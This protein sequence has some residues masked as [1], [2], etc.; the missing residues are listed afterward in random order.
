MG[1]PVR[2]P[3]SKIATPD[4]PAGFAARHHLLEQLDRATAEQLLVVIAP[5]GYGKTVLL[6]DW[7]RQPGGPPTAWITVDAGD[8]AP[9]LWS[10]LLAALRAIPNLPAD[11]PLHDVGRGG[12]RAVDVVD[13]LAAA[14]DATRQPI[15][16]VLDDVHELAAPAAVGGLT[17]L[18][19]HRPA[20]LRLVLSSRADPPL[21]LPR[22]RLEGRLHELRADA[23]RF[24]VE[25]AAALLRASGLDVGADQ[26]AVLHART[27]GWAAGLRLAAL[28]LRGRDDPKAFISH[29]SGSE[30]S[31]ADYLTGEVMAG[32]PVPA[33]EFLRD[34]A[35]CSELPVGLAVALSGRPDAGRVLDELT[36]DTALVQRT[37]P[38]T[39]RVH[40]LLRTYLVA[41]LGRHLPTRHR[42]S[43]AT[44]A[45][46]WLGANDPVHALRHA[47]QAAEPAQLHALLRET[48]VGLVATGQIALLRHALD[49]A[50]PPASADPWP[51]L[52]AALSHCAAGA[53]PDAAAALGQARR[54]WPTDPEPA[55]EV[56]R[57]S[58]ELL[59]TG[60]RTP[61]SP[62][63]DPRGPVP[64]DLGALL[65]LSRGVAALRA[66]EGA[67]PADLR[68]DLEGVVALAC[69]RGWRFFEVQAL[70][71]LASLDAARG[72]YA[73]M[74]AEA[75]AAV[76]AAADQGWEPAGWS[77]GASALIAY[78]DL[79]AG[80]PDAARI[81]TEAV[82]GAGSSPL[83][84]EVELALRAVHGAALGDAGEYA[85]GLAE[86]RAARVA[87]GEGAGPAPLLTALAVLEQRAALAQG[88]SAG[89]AEVGEWLERRV[90]KVG[91]VL[92]MDA[93]AH[94]AAGQYPAARSAIE[95]LS[96]GSVPTLLGH[97]PV[98]THLVRA[99]VALQSDDPDGGRTELESA[100]ALGAA[101]DVVRPFLLAGSSSRELLRSDPPI[102]PG[103]GF[104]ERLA[105]ALATVREDTPAPL[106][107]REL[108]VLA[109]LPSL[110]SAGDI[111]D[112]LTVSVNT[113]KSHIRSIYAK[114]GVSTRRDA[115]RRAHERNLFG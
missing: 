37:N 35:V 80:D 47:E 104:A 26:V 65:H 9:R 48:G 27:E 74:T 83:A 86:S 22:L 46:W 88:D 106:S 108:A 4:L 44:A 110:L 85:A 100:L 59:V 97:T 89:A 105:A 43:H 76:A 31:V 58:V 115:V 15:R 114:F 14:L 3:V 69:E 20:G 23:L 2:T 51:P 21:P 18:I 91:E 45:R 90:G 6:S 41:E 63:V 34:T 40:T 64:P 53:P 93:W 92:I 72:R 81:R 79:L 98:D 61:G 24:T 12:T 10:A 75:R 8:D 66:P 11:S 87:F 84:A 1:D 111:A 78:G 103:A 101:L 73:A 38:G 94:L 16:V 49:V 62:Q 113:V 30:R 7:L 17:R 95:P 55:L 112:E 56:L 36:R 19:R 68:A 99:E 28:A 25:E 82:L 52:L 5:P 109:L 54:V 70:S 42:R 13:Q 33:R 67:D 71:L 102:P 60:R 107:E 96:A 32:L 50:G 57:A 39:Y 29:F 77:A